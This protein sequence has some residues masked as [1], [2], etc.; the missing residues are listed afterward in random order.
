MSK[1]LIKQKN[2]V[3]SFVHPYHISLNEKI[4]DDSKSFIFKEGLRNIGGA[5]SNV[6]APKTTET[7]ITSKSLE[8]VYDWILTLLNQTYRGWNFKIYNSWLANYSKGQYTVSHDHVPSSFSFVYFVKSPKG[9]SPLVF[10]NSGTKI[11]PDEGKVVI[12]PGNML[13]Q[14][15]KNKCDGRMTLAGNILPDMSTYY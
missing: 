6:R 2:E 8:L 4:L 15:P 14:V 7:R 13:H 5:L 3:F 12:F 9:S 10:T 11:N 1:K